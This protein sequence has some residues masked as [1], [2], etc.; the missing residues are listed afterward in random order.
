MLDPDLVARDLPDGVHDGLEEDVV[1]RELRPIIRDAGQVVVVV[2]GQEG[3]LHPL[4]GLAE[5]AEQ[6]GMLR[7]DGLELGDTRAVGQL[8]KAEGIADDNELGGL[9]SR[10][11]FP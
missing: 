9:R 6:G 2:A 1:R 5:L 11:D 3:D 10:C 7:G 4:A 8:P